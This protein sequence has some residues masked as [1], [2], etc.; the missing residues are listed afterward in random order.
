MKM[1]EIGAMEYTSVLGTRE[2]RR[3]RLADTASL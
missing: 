1:P 2:V 3:I